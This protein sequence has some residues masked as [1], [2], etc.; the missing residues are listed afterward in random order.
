MS[1][2]PFIFDF[3]Y[4]NFFVRVEKVPDSYDVF[5]FIIGPN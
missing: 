1:T 4:L 5:Y 3:F 2:L